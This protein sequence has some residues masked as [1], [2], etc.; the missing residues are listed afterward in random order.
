MSNTSSLANAKLLI[1]DLDGTLVDTICDLAESVDYALKQLHLPTH[2]YEEYKTFVGDGTKILIQ[3]SLPKELC[4]NNE[5][6]NKA[7]AYFIKY[8]SKH[9]ADK[10]K[11]Y[12]GML[13]SLTKLKYSGIRL[14]VLSNKPDAFTNAIIR[15][16]F[17]EG[18][19]DYVL[20]ACDGVPKKPDPTSEIYLIDKLR[21]RKEDTLHVGDSDID[22]VAAH[23]AG[24]KC[25]GCSW[26]YR[27]LE[28]LKAAGA[29][30]IISSPEELVKLFEK[31][32]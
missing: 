14:A 27:S 28:C 26:G 12:D 19:F 22:V 30:G 3:R 24:V 4:D 23:N 31:N 2:T 17:P 11:I 15:E 21:F 7:H 29:D 1:F 16:L 20:G 6:L 10:S 13:E 9:Y 32:S 18:L 25:L 8:Y 5:I